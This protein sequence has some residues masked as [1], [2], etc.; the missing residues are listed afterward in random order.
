MPAPL[1]R[2]G[3]LMGLKV[4]V[5]VINGQAVTRFNGNNPSTSNFRGST[6][7]TSNKSAKITAWRKAKAAKRASREWTYA[8]KYLDG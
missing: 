6:W 2:R 5:E 4:S 8:R 7:E 1:I 3:H